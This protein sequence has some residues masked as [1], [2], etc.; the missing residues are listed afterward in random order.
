MGELPTGTITML[1]SDVEGSTALL[2]RL[3]DRYGEALSA[4]RAIQRA[5]FAE[6]G[7]HEMG[8][9]GDSFFAVFASAAD[10]A[11][12]CVAAQHELAGHD[13][14]E[15]ITL[16][17]RMGLH[18]GEPARHEDGY[19]GMDV[20][21][22]ARI[23]AAAHG[24]QVV[25]SDAARLLAAPHLP[26]N[27]SFHDLGFHRLKDIE[28][29]E[30]VFQLTA[31]GL[32][33]RFPPLRSLGAATSFP[34]PMTPLVGRDDEL[35]ALCA[36]VARPGVRLVTLTGPGGVGKTRLGLAGAAL[37]HHAF[38]HGS[39]FVPL[40]PVRDADVMWKTI[41]GSLDAAGDG[42]DAEVVTGFLRER[43][44]LLVLDNLEQL[45][46][47]A[48]VV[49][50]LLLAAPELV[51]LATSRRPLHVHGEHEL[52]VP[53][54][55]VPGGGRAGEVAASGA[56]MLFAQQAQLVR[57]GFTI[58][59]GNAAD[60]A[61]I[62][63]RLD[64][65]PLAIELAA[66]RAKL[67]TPKALLARLGDSL[68][69]AA[70][71]TGRPQRQRTLRGTI[72]WSYDLLSPALAAVFR[73]VGVFAGGA[74][75]D[76][77]TAVAAVGL[78]GG[79]AAE[80]DPLELAAELQDLSLI[81]VTEG[82]DG[83]PRVGMLETI[84][85]YALERLAEAGELD[86]ARRRHAQHYAALAE[87]AHER[88]GGPQ[89]L[90]AMDRLEAEQANLRAALIWSLDTPA[91]DP[92]ER[93]EHAA[94]GLWLARELAFFWYDHGHAT[95]GRRWLERATELA[96]DDAGAPLARAVHGL[97]VLLAQQGEH[98]RAVELLERNVALWRKLGDREQESRE[99]N[100]LGATYH[101]LGDLR[102]ARS[103]LERST[104][105]GR[106]L[107]SDHRVAIALGNL[108]QVESNAGDLDRATELL[109]ES[110]ALY[111]KLGDEAGV[112]IDIESLAV[113]SLRAGRPHEARDL[114]AGVVVYAANSG[115]TE[116]LASSLEVAACIAA[117][118]G[119]RPPA[120]CLAG[121]AEAL[122]QQAGMPIPQPD[123]AL[124]DRFLAPA[125]AATAPG[126]WDAELAT[127]RALSQQQAAVLLRSA[128]ARA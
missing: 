72:T 17:V 18:S 118:R 64:G 41:A 29:P 125:R 120:A 67:L 50:A 66:S 75:L 7:G 103:F 105:I 16:R 31:A 49:A 38:P 27:V 14:P 98:S 106:E 12:S 61:A 63:A 11:W 80:S 112:A 3:G 90:A 37:L 42:P 34:A 97:A 76:A 82:P 48:T 122:R 6:F 58:T 53:P 36:T 19:I 60:V 127:G 101:Y 109:R 107:R 81:T 104:E 4:Q 87:W 57:P 84:R 111:R 39:Y 68:A 9:E 89:Q 113:V 70:T 86:E 52:P 96:P 33:E 88:Y 21:R 26:A 100:S 126:V 93:A 32:P 78:P 114:L 28:A 115:D 92:A 91:E 74:S 71:D 119:G 20:H 62:C 65:L 79:D 54:L 99:L 35:A 1:F 121:A 45:D 25:A 83:E 40:A 44:A 23:A 56:A 123:A 2:S 108:G 13:W 124:L 43:R 22:A 110:L 55:S 8:T 59:E 128:V 73:R 46:G 30:H 47:A 102:T 24:G 5:A 15:G 69:L 116:F 95:E 10:A 117:A 77:L 51:I 85:D 94:I